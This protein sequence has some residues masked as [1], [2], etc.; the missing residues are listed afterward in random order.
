MEART[1]LLELTSKYAVRDEPTVNDGHKH[2]DQDLGTELRGN[3][4]LPA[5]DLPIHSVSTTVARAST[6]TA[7]VYHQRKHSRMDQ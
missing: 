6:T 2:R 3:V 1:T 4:S 5:N 7:R